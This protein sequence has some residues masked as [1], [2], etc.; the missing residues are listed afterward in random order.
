MSA[1]DNKQNCCGTGKECEC[2]E[3]RLRRGLP[4]A[5][6]ASSSYFY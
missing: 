1:V 6:G 3:V 2:G 4:I 5:C